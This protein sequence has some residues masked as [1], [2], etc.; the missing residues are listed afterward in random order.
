VSLD[1]IEFPV[2]VKE[3]LGAELGL[4]RVELEDMEAGELGVISGSAMLKDETR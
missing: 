3:N 2:E 4:F 1:R